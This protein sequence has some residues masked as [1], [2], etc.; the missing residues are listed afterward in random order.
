VVAR[1]LAVYLDNADDD[2]RRNLTTSVAAT[3]E[4]LLSDHDEWTRHRWIDGLDIDRVDRSGQLGVEIHGVIQWSDG[5]KWF[6]DPCSATVELTGSGEGLARFEAVI[7]DAATGLGTVPF[8]E[9]R[10]DSWAD[11]SEWFLALH[12]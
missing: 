2:N 9:K 1:D 6:I 10:P 4:L 12:G 3:M 5:R 11:L 8:G 7:G